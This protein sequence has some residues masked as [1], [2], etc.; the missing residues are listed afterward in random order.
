MGYS[1]LTMLWLF[2]G[3]STGTQPFVCRYPFS[4]KLPSHPGCHITQLSSLCYTVGPGW[5]TLSFKINKWYWY[6]AFLRFQWLRALRPY[7]HQQKHHFSRCASRFLVLER[8][9]RSCVNLPSSCKN[10]T[11]VHSDPQNRNWWMEA[12]TCAILSCH[13]LALPFTSWKCPCDTQNSFQEGTLPVRGK[14]WMASSAS[15]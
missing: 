5:Q 7:P 12:G 6:L 11:G 8:F 9:L 10:T 3:D 14:A 2:Q 4:P 15:Y 1:L 13:L